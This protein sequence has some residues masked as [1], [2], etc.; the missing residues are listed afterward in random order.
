VPVPVLL[1]T[2]SWDPGK[3]GLALRSCVTTTIIRDHPYL[4]AKKFGPDAIPQLFDRGRIALFL[5]GWD[6]MS[7]AV[8]DKALEGLT[9]E[10]AGLRV[11][12][13]SRPEGFG[14]TLDTGQQLPY[15]EV[16]E[17]RPV[18]PQSAVEYLFEGQVGSTRPAWQDVGDHL[19]MHQD[20]Y[21]HG[22]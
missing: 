7:K 10:A 14:D 22:H 18:D 8:R 2:G 1:T 4:L 5:D 9:T 20:G 12:M 15:A 11:V 21:W 19:V 16:V 6:E 13:T 17:L 3:K